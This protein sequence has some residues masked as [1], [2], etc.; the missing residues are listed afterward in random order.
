[1]QSCL[2]YTSS[3]LQPKPSDYQARGA[4]Y[5]PENARL[6]DLGMRLAIAHRPSELRGQIV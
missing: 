1:M 5:L 4:I 3:R 6:S 2:R